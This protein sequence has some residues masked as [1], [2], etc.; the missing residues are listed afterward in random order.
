VLLA[1]AALLGTLGGLWHGGALRH[2]AR[3]SFRWPLIF[4]AGLLLRAVAFSPLVSHGGAAS[5]LYAVALALLVTG[6]AVNR[7][8]VGIELVLLGLLL[9]AAVILANGGAMPI[10]TDALRSI[11]QYDFALRLRDQGPIGHVALATPETLLRGLADVIP[12][13]PLPFLGL[14]VSIG[15]L[16]IATG[17]LV[18]FY[19]G[20]LGGAESRQS[21]V[22]SRQWRRGGDPTQSSAANPSDD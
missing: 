4:L 15:D 17:V 8:I 21:P 19:F 13:A 18:I 1:L 14:V 7:R 5:A 16:L 9:N 2:F 11:G 20:T 12:L 6:M 22:G 10:T 3:L